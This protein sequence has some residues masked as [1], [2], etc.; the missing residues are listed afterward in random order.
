MF[1]FKYKKTDENRSN[2]R[3]TEIFEQSIIDNTETTQI[4]FFF[5]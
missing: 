4:L 1:F 3:E 5:L 2:L